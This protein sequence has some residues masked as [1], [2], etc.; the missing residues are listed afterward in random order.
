VKTKKGM[1]PK[2]KEGIVELIEQK[3]EM[4]LV[5]KTCNIIN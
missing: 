4:F 3:K 5:E 1:A 2:K